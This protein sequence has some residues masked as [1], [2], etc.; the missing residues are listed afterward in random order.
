VKLV[1][2]AIAARAA[3]FG[4]TTDDPSG[5]AR[6]RSL[7]QEKYGGRERWLGLTVDTSRSVAVQLH[8]AKE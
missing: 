6:I 4:A 7:I 8:P 1:L 3:A 2:I 5:H